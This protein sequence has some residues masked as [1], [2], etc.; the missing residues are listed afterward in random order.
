MAEIIVTA[1]RREQSLQDVSIAIAAFPEERI[2]DLDIESG[3][4]IGKLTPGL[5]VSNGGGGQSLQF[6]IRGVTQ[7]DFSDIFEGPIAVYIDDTYIPFLQGQIFATFDLERV[8]V[9]KG[10]QGTLFGKNAT[11][12]LVHYIPKH[13]SQE[14]EGFVRLQYGRFNSVRAEAALGGGL[15][16]TISARASILF[17]RNDAFVDNI[18][19]FGHPPFFPAIP[20]QAPFGQ[21]LGKQETLIGRL[22]LRGEFGDLDVRISGTAGGV[23][24]GSSPY[25]SRGV[26]PIFN[27]FGQHVNTVLNLPGVPSG[28]GAISPPSIFDTA[29]DF[30]RSDGNFS[31]VYDLSGHIEYDFG[32]MTLTAVSSY[33]KFKKD[34]GL[35]IDGG[36][37][38]FTGAALAN[39]SDSFSQELRLTGELGTTKFSTGLFYISSEGDS[40]AGFLAPGNSLLAGAFGPVIGAS[41]LDL[42]NTVRFKNTDYSAFAQLDIPLFN[43]ITFVVG[44]RIVRN[45]Q[46]FDFKSEGYLNID[47]FEI[48]TGTVILPNFQ[49]PFSDKRHKTLWAAR[50]VVEYRPTTDHLFYV[51]YN[52]G[53]KAGAYNGKFPDFTPPLTPDEIIYGSET[54]QSYEGGFKLTL[55]DRALNLNGAAFYYDYQDYQVFQLSN[56][57]GIVFNKDAET[58]GFEASADFLLGR[59]LRGAFSYAYTHATINDVAVAPA[60]PNV[61]PTVFRD[62]QPAFSPRHQISGNL[63]YT[64]PSEVLGGDASF[65]LVGRYI[66]NFFDNPRNYDASRQQGYELFDAGVRWQSDD[67]WEVAFDVRNVFNKKYVETAFDT[68]TIC[69]C[70]QIHY[71]KPR[72]WAVSLGKKI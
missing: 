64:L 13:P 2:A 27:Q 16:D 5:F 67:G 66:S 60:V 31:D 8:E 72:W 1:N 19:P 32:R 30:A 53:V 62:T 10:P 28:L 41:G 6:S 43:Q 63:L 4:D 56:G 21:D 29:A 22:Q 23:N 45:E 65:R 39:V 42:I 35:D 55:F 26:T 33:K 70:S 68:A 48:D 7:A 9:L 44:G 36:P 52:R 11:G 58:Y 14:T 3:L 12:G 54:L 24:L 61:A 46:E 34:I 47:D 50:A 51:G 40:L 59:L 49:P 15:S 69:G 25:S 20:P 17:D 18:Y 37:V 71:G 57:S 38:N